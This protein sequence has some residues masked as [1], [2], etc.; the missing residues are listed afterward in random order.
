MSTTRSSL[1]MLSA[2]S[3]KNG[4]GGG[5]SGET[6]VGCGSVCTSTELTASP[7]SCGK[8]AVPA[9]MAGALPEAL[10]P[11]PPGLRRVGRAGGDDCGRESGKRLPPAPL[12]PGLISPPRQPAHPPAVA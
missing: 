12:L 11:A 8:V 6:C 7:A 5:A 2:S 3:W 9:D 1:L 4:D 10:P